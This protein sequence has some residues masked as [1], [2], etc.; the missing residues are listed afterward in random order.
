MSGRTHRT[1]FECPLC[2]HHNLTTDA[3]REHIK[4]KH[5]LT[6]FELFDGIVRVEIVGRDG[7]TITKGLEP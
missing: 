7:E 5:Y 3:M 4:A 2:D 1:I 6:G